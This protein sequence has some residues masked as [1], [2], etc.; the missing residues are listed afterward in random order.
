MMRLFFCVGFCVLFGEVR[1][2]M[3]VK[4]LISGWVSS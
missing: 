2:S 1:M 3:V 4:V